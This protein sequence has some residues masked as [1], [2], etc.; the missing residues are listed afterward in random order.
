MNEINRDFQLKSVN[1]NGDRE[2]SAFSQLPRL[3]IISSSKSDW[4]NIQVTH[5]HQPASEIPEHN[6][7]YHGIYLNGGKTV[8]LEQKIAGKIITSN[9][10]PGD[11]GIYPAHISQSFAWN[12]EADFLLIYLEPDLITKLGYELYQSNSVELIPQIESSFDPLIQEIAIA[13]KNALENKVSSNLYA[14]SM[15]N[16]LAV[17]LLSR[18]SNRSCPLKSSKGKLSQPQLNQVIDYIY[19]NLDKNLTLTQLAAVIQ[20]S[21]YHFAR[22][23]KQTTGKAPHQFQLQCRINRAKELLLKNMAIAEVAQTT[24]FSSQSHLNYHFKR[25]VGATPK[26]FLAHSKNL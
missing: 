5:H 16:A 13:L 25:R 2:I 3:P 6:S 21:E 23:F 12:S 15:A 1:S 19:S 17:H 26:Q 8:K 7:D 14:D 4:K 10:I 18:Y 11:F 24:G 9:S 20:L 22:L